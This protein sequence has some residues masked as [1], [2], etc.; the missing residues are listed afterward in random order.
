MNK[1]NLYGAVLRMVKDKFKMDEYDINEFNKIIANEKTDF[2]CSQLPCNSV[3][4]HTGDFA[5]GSNFL[6]EIRD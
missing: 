2:F 5:P 3:N 6:P 4:G 1:E